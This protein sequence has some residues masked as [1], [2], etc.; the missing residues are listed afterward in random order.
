MRK[1][2]FSNLIETRL[3]SLVP[4]GGYNWNTEDALDPDEKH[5]AL[6]SFPSTRQSH[7]TR[8]GKV[9]I[10]FK[11][12]IKCDEMLQCMTAASKEAAMFETKCFISKF[13][14]L[15]LCLLQH[16]ISQLFTHI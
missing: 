10:I 16:G 1:G 4:A 9:L 5:R 13:L 7:E 14:F 12:C 3:D 6:K 8:K 11:T 15:L 2:Y